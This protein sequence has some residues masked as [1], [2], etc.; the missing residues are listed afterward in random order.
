[1][2]LCRASDASRRALVVRA[3]CYWTVWCVRVFGGISY[4]I[5]GTLPQP[6]CVIVANHQ[7]SFDCPL[8]WRV[9]GQPSLV[10]RKELRPFFAAHKVMHII[11][12]DRE[13]RQELLSMCREVAAELQSGRS[14]LI[15]AEGTRMAPGS[16][17]KLKPGLAGLYAALGRLPERARFAPVILDAGAFW[18]KNTFLKKAGR[19]T[20]K[21]LPI[22]TYDPEVKPRDFL[23]NMEAAMN[24]AQRKDMR[25]EGA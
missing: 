16:E 22:V 23:V 9:C 21:F 5:I 17:I 13:S 19:L 25:L 20:I 1:M 18:P 15:F 4:R 6:P 8:L 7:S 10:A 3:S 12:V 24:E 11:W 14:V 2:T